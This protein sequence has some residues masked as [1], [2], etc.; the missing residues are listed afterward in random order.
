MRTWIAI[1]VDMEEEAFFT[2]Y[3]WNL[4]FRWS[5]FDFRDQLDS[6]SCNPSTGTPQKSTKSNLS[7][8]DSSQNR[9][10]CMKCREEGRWLET[11][12]TLTSKQCLSL[13]TIPTQTAHKVFRC[14]TRA[15]SHRVVLPCCMRYVHVILNGR[16][17]F[18]FISH[19]KQ[20]ED[21]TSTL[22]Y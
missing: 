19:L 22:V 21:Q 7:A 8:E 20:I 6:Q 17:H 10:L 11:A 9:Q 15:N 18:C 16:F 3:E 5:T 14:W 13:S 1:H 4:Y 12:C 2:H